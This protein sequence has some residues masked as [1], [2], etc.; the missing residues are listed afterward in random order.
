MAYEIQGT[1]YSRKEKQQ[2][3][4]KFAKQEFIIVTEG[5]YPEHVAM[6][7]VNDNC[8]FLKGLAK[9]DLIKVSFNLKGKPFKNKQGE[10]VV[11]TNVTA[12][13]IEVVQKANTQTTP[14]KVETKKAP[15]TPPPQDDNIDDL[16]F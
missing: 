13:K 15:T 10:E 12:Y 3:T 9:G 5:Q 11:M 7:C 4:E 8:N 2:V 14:P 1:L 16:P 6:Q